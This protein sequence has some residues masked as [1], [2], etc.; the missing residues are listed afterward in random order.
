M[1]RAD[2][3]RAAWQRL[4]ERHERTA[5]RYL[6]TPTPEQRQELQAALDDLET[7]RAELKAKQD[8]AR[9]AGL[10]VDT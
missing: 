8:E 10:D 7:A 9:A 1:T 3:L 4:Q 2:P 5:A 6:G